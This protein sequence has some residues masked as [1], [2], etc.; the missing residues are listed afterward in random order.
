MYR[1]IQNDFL[2]F[3]QEVSNDKSQQGNTL[4]A[5]IHYTL[6]TTLYKQND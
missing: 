3:P 5:S 6:Q 4:S 1:R 2:V